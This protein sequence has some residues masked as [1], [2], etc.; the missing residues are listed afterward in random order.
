MRSSDEYDFEDEQEPNADSFM[1]KA[2]YKRMPYNDK[3]QKLYWSEKQ[4][5]YKL[6]SIYYASSIYLAYLTK[7]YFVR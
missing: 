3:K 7:E 5:S 2:Y 1:L 6:H 4:F